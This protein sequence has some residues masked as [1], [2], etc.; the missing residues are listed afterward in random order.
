VAK[1]ALTKRAMQFITAEVEVQGNPV[2]RPGALVNIKKVGAYSGHYLVTEANH[3]YDAAG[4]NCI[5]Y[6]A[7]DKWGNSSQPPQAAQPQ[8]QAA[9]RQQATP[10]VIKDG[11]HR[12]LVDEE[13]GDPLANVDYEI[14][15][16]GGETRN[17]KTDANGFLEEN[18][19]PAGNFIVRVLFDDAEVFEPPPVTLR[20]DDSDERPAQADEPSSLEVAARAVV[21]IGVVSVEPGRAFQGETVKLSAEVIGAAD[22]TALMFRI[23]PLE[24]GAAVAEVEAQVASERAEASW[25]LSAVEATGKQNGFDYADL[26]VEADCAGLVRRAAEV[27]ALRAFCGPACFLS[28]VIRSVGGTPLMNQLVEVIDPDTG[29]TVGPPVTTDAEGHIAVKVPENKKYAI[30]ILDDD[31]GDDAPPPEALDPYDA[32]QDD[33]PRIFIRLLDG[34][35][36]P[37]AGV[38]YEVTGKGGVSHKGKTDADGDVE[39]EGVPAGGYELKV[40][41]KKFQIPTIVS[42]VL[43]EDPTPYTLI[44]K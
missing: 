34:N 19:V 22:G 23:F 5:F 14:T 26:D 39:M 35:G 24:G 43:R 12:R 37:L 44:V 7:R 2:V 17:G 40:Q 31:P 18:D 41:G 32:A 13:T 9:A 6:V 29:E 15:L 1:A 8:Q 20:L 27:P 42:S 30:R 11:I 25:K 28:T 36:K 3:F 38:D 33:P 16:H 10:A 4:Y 21:H